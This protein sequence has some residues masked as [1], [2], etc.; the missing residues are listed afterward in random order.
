MPNRVQLTRTSGWLRSPGQ[1]GP[2]ALMQQVQVKSCRGLIWE[3]YQLRLS[4]ET[5]RVEPRL[6]AEI[7]VGC[8]TC[9]DPC[10]GV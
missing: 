9:A 2:S 10:R 8:A 4:H 7:F 3:R 6:W 5:F 1:G